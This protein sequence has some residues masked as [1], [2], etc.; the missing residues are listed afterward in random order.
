M[1]K[2]VKKFLVA[3]DKSVEFM[4]KCEDHMKVRRIDHFGTSLVYPDFFFNSLAA[5]TVAVTAGI[6]MNVGIATFG[7]LA[8]IVSHTGGFAAQDR[9]GSLLLDIRLKKS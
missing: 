6:V 5:G 3:V 7:T 2:P 4:R 9:I 8:K 1:K